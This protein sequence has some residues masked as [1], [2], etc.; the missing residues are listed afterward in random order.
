MSDPYRDAET[1][2]KATLDERR[3][4]LQA[5]DEKLIPMHER[6]EELVGEIDALEARLGSLRYRDEARRSS[7]PAI[8]GF[9]LV[10]TSAFSAAYLMLRPPHAGCGVSRAHMA[11][12][13]TRQLKMLA[14]EHLERADSACPSVQDV[15]GENTRLA[16]DPWGNPY[17][18]SCGDGEVVVSSNGPDGIAA[19]RDDIR[20][21]RKPHRR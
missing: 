20:D 9:G 6:H 8:I 2:L 12:S 21:N 11:W 16:R 5:L 19:T 13:D 18:I 15:V 3:A 14:D 4:E 17:R 1:L 10:V 7:R